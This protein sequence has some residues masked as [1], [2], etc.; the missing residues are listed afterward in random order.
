MNV[1]IQAFGDEV[2]RCKFGVTWQVGGEFPVGHSQYSFEA[3]AANTATANMSQGAAFSRIWGSDDVVPQGHT[4]YSF[5]YG[6]GRTAGGPVATSS[7]SS[8]S[9]SAVV[10][11]VAAKAN[12][13]GAGGGEKKADKKKASSDKAV[14]KK[15]VNPAGPLT[16]ASSNDLGMDQEIYEAMQKLDLRVGE[17]IQVDRIPD[18]EALY[19][20][21]IA[22]GNDVTR[23]ICSGIVKYYKPDELLH[24]KVIAYYNIKPCKMAGEASEGMVLAGV[25]DSKLPT[26]QCEVL[27]IEGGGKD[28]LVGTKVEL[29]CNGKSMSCGSVETSSKNISKQWGKAQPLFSIVEKKAFLESAGKS[30]AW[31]VKSAAGKY[32]PVVVKTLKKGI[33][34]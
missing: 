26:E 29:F 25:F 15:A 24:R 13:A 32:L 34:S 19:K 11:P 7:S 31:Q 14:E 9:S 22:M 6:T 33:I 28:V 27:D 12:N 16:G 30:F 4:Q 3:T 18:S 8:S 1:V 23:Q 20:L 5:F 2:V 17:V 21:Q 10:P